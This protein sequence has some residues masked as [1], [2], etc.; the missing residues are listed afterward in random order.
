MHDNRLTSE[1]ATL[2]ARVG[3]ER[4]IMLSGIKHDQTEGDFHRQSLSLEDIILIA[5]DLAASASM[6]SI[7]L[8]SN[9]L[10]PEGAKYIA[11]GIAASSSLTQVLAF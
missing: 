5:S 8:K 2:L 1:S 3:T 9:C 6:A 11:E 10:G 4:R 7:N